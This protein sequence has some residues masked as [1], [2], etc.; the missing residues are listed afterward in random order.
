ML[1]GRNRNELD[2]L[3]EGARCWDGCVEDE[4]DSDI[5][6][7]EHIWSDTEWWASEEITYPEDEAVETDGVKYVEAVTIPSTWNLLYD[8]AVNQDIEYGTITILGRLRFDPEAKCDSLSL[9]A[10]NIFVQ[11]GEFLIQ[12]RDDDDGVPTEY[13]IPVT[14]TLLGGKEDYQITTNTEVDTGNKNI[15]VGG[16]T[17]MYGKSRSLYMT[18]LTREV[19]P[20]DD[21]ICVGEVGD[22]VA[23]DELGIAPTRMDPLERDW[24]VITSIT[25]P[26]ETDCAFKVNFDDSDDTTEEKM[27]YYHFGSTIEDWSDHLDID[28]RGEVFLLSRSIKIVGEDEETWGG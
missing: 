8:C 20:G 21:H 19:E 12:G 9:K 5:S 17:S 10:H 3:I 28:M 7:I 4:G 25:E 24:G 1:D 6:D 13:H 2:L 26:G 14:I 27:S 18:R 22:W 16:K 23:G 15:I 11:G